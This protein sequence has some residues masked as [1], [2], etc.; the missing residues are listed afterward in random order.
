MAEYNVSEGFTVQHYGHDDWFP[1]V[2]ADYWVREHLGCDEDCTV[3]VE[4]RDEPGARATWGEVRAALEMLG[5]CGPY[6][7]GP[8]FAELTYNHENSL[9]NELLIAA[10]WVDMGEQWATRGLPCD[11]LSA[12]KSQHY[13]GHN[14]NEI[15]RVWV[16]A[17]ADGG[18]Y[19]DAGATADVYVDPNMDDDYD[20][21]RWE[22]QLI[23]NYWDETGRRGSHPV[24]D[25][26][27]FG[28]GTDDLDGTGYPW[29]VNEDRMD[30]W[31]LSEM[32]AEDEPGED[33]PAVG[34]F[35]AIGGAG[36]FAVG[37]SG[38][39]YPVSGWVN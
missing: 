6:R 11:L 20:V 33:Y 16:V 18:A 36:M 12:I 32:S 8:V 30:C 26:C 5:D 25:A 9:S 35:L 4:S 2:D 29:G 3:E 1:E 34:P 21:V 28:G 13:A 10:G 19:G 7:E 24:W 15:S 14:W 22:V 38:R 39:V 27:G 37:R 31:D 17:I 23:A